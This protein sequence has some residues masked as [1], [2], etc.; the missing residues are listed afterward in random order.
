MD[1]VLLG[2]SRSESSFADAAGAE[3]EDYGEHD[4]ATGADRGGIVPVLQFWQMTF[5]DFEDS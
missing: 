4:F 1:V 3:E 5:S 2:E